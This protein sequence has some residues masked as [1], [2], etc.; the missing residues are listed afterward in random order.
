M[1]YIAIVEPGDALFRCLSG[2]PQPVRALG[3]SGGQGALVVVGP[4]C[5]RLP[6]GPLRCRILLLP[7]PLAALAGQVQAGWVVSYGL[8][9]RDTLT[10]SSL[11]PRRPCLTLQRELV[12]LAGT[13]LE[14]QELPLPPF[15]SPP[16][17]LL[18]LAWAG[19]CLLA[20]ADPVTLGKNPCPFPGKRL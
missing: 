11:S 15:S 8:S 20:G 18:L 7:G 6:P 10:L 17:P 2:L 5:R 3:P 16:S 4:D 1:A 13:C 9:R 14:P 12:T 19:T